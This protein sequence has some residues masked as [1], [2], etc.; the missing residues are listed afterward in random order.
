MLYIAPMKQITWNDTITL[1]RLFNIDLN[2]VPL[3]VFKYAIEVELEHGL[4]HHQT[5]V[6]D[7]DLVKTTKI[8]LAH[9]HE[10]PDYYQR[11][12][13]MEAE[14]EEYWKNKSMPLVDYGHS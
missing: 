5:N 3:P 14:A 11:L 1:A 9:L 7:D 4:I 8:A 12:K 10:F 13:K 2:V 6:T